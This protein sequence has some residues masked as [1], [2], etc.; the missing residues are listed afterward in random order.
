MKAIGIR[1]KDGEIPLGP[2][3][4][5]IPRKKL[6]DVFPDGIAEGKMPKEPICI[7]DGKYI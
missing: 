5:P 7:E 4:K 6:R 3:W 2:N 1:F